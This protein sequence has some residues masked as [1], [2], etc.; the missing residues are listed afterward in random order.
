[1]VNKLESLEAEGFA[2]PVWKFGEVPGVSIDFH[3]SVVF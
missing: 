3:G 2:V 1:M